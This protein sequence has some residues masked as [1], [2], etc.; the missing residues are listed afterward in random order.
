M[1]LMSLSLS[2]LSGVTGAIRV[3]LEAEIVF[4][5]NE[6]KIAWQIVE[7]G[8]GDLKVLLNCQALLE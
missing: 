2:R 1:K 3:E 7:D 6:L 4:V 8:K 5:E